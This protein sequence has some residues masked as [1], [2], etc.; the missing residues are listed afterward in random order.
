V[1][2]LVVG[3]VRHLRRRGLV[4]YL[5]IICSSLALTAFGVP[6][7]LRSLGTP[8]S[9]GTGP[10]V[11]LVGS[12]VF[13]AGVSIFGVVWNTVMQELVPGEMLGRVSSIDWLGSFAFEPVG[14]GLA[15]VL[16]DRF[17]PALVFVGGGVLMW[18]LSVLALTVRGVRELE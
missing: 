6:A 2:T 9:T 10:I 5:S 8:I 12:A 4:A 3:Q 7:V 15:G 14:L 16:A 17:G 11:I 1:A 18:V 13:S